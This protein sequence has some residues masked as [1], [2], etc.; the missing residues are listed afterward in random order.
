MTA[1][2][3][4]TCLL[5]AFGAIV[6]SMLFPPGDVLRQL[7]VVAVWYLLGAVT[8]WLWLKGS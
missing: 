6:S 5:I 1:N 2:L 7:T 8:V 3:I 4:G